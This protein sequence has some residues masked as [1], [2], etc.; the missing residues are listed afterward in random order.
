VGSMAGLVGAKFSRAYRSSVANRGRKK[1]E[2]REKR[3]W[4]SMGKRAEEGG[5]V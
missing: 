5:T 4:T 1:E 3:E 2:S